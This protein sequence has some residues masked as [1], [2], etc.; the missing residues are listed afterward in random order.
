MGGGSKVWRRGSIHH[1]PMRNATLPEAPKRP[2]SLA[3]PQLQ[4]FAWADR[5]PTYSD[6]VRL[7]RS[8]CVRG[9][10]TD[11][12]ACAAAATRFARLS[13]QRGSAV[14]GSHIRGRC[15]CRRR[16]RGASGGSARQRGG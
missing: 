10:G 4:C 9:L 2:A 8:L 3:L 11:G 16:G 14:V 15:R 1:G 12:R 7:F 13:W 6:V 5:P